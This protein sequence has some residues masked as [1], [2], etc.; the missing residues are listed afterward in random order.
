MTDIEYEDIARF[1]RLHYEYEGGTRRAVDDGR[2]TLQEL[3]M[4]HYIMQ[5]TNENTP[6]QIEGEQWDAA[7]NRWLANLPQGFAVAARVFGVSDLE[8]KLI[9][10][11]VCG[12]PRTEP[13]YIAKY[14]DKTSSKS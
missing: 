5:W 12:I 2:M 9:Y 14:G 7:H 4:Y 11:K 3:T 1:A 13:G 10:E 6:E 8:S